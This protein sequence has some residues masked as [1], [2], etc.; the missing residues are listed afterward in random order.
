MIEWITTGVRA[1]IAEDWLIYINENYID[2]KTTWR[3]EYLGHVRVSGVA[4]DLNEAKAR[5]TVCAK[6]LITINRE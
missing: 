1:C 3:V 5:A 2:G 4:R 6:N